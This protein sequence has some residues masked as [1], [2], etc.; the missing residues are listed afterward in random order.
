MRS[1]N[2]CGQHR[3]SSLPSEQLCSR[4]KRR[5]IRV[6]KPRFVSFPLL[7]DTTTRSVRSKCI[8]VERERE[9]ERE[10]E[11]ER[12]RERERVQSLRGE[13]LLCCSVKKPACREFHLQKRA[14]K[15]SR[16]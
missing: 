14:V 5:N 15:T 8:P 13:R 3:F 4:L 6:G 7:Y 10:R 2:H 9:R 16:L 12:E 1:S 11:G